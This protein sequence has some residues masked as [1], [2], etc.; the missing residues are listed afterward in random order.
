M[1]TSKVHDQRH[2]GFSDLVRV[3]STNPDAFVVDVKHDLGG[4]VLSLSEEPLQ[5]QHD[6]FHRRVVIIEQQN[7]VERRLLGFG[8]CLCDD[9]CTAFIVVPTTVAPHRLFGCHRSV[10]PAAALM[11]ATSCH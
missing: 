4:L 7:L 3:Y 9:T 11:V 10:K 5:H 8:P 1:L 6:E 2:L